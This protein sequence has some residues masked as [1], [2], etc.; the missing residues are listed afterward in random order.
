MIRGKRKYRNRCRVICLLLVCLSNAC[1]NDTMVTHDDTGSIIANGYEL[2]LATTRTVVQTIGSEVAPQTKKF[3]QIEVTEVINLQ[4]IPLSFS[5]HYQSVQGERILLGT[6]SLFPPDNP[7]NF[8]VAT[9]GKLRI[10]GMIIV[11]MIPLEEVRDPEAI[12]V[13]LKRISFIG[14]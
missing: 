5:V 8:I 11:S 2:N 7:G 1:A 12:Q 13:R 14:D 9:Q 3:V 4:K 10:G 6:F